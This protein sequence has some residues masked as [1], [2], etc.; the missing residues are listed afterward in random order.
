MNLS[1]VSK[2]LWC[3]H[4]L[5]ILLLTPLLLLPLVFTL[6]EKEGRCLYV[7]IL[8]AVYWC[9]EALPLAVT[10]ML[11]VCLFPTLGILPSKK[12]CPQYFLE[13]NFLFLSGLVMASSIEEWGLHRRIALKVLTIVGVKPA[14]LILGM[15]LT[16][17][18]LSMWLSNT[19]TTAMMLPIATAILESL[20]GD[21]ETLKE[22]CKERQEPDNEVR[23]PVKLH[24]LPS[25]H[26]EKQ[27]LSIEGP[28]VEEQS[29]QRSVEEIRTES[30]YQ[31]KVWKGFLI[32]IPYAASIGGTATLTGTAPNLILIG[33]LKS[34]FPD[35]D[36][37]NFG[38]WFAFAFPL[39]A[40]LPVVG[41]L[42]IAFLHGGL[43]TRLCFTRTDH[44]AAAEARARTM[45]EDDYK[46]LGPIK[47]YPQIT[48][49]LSL[50]AIHVSIN[51]LYFMI[52]ATVGCSYAFMLPVSTPPNSIAFASGHLMVK[53]MVKTGIVMNIL[54]ILCVSLAMNTWGVAMFDL[55]SY[56]EWAHPINKTL[57]DVH[58][59]LNATL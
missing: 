18:F 19:A 23:L 14:W 48:S 39:H 41:W 33:Q 15:M 12:V 36:A 3:V 58:L 50:Q 32:C 20:F 27:M 28:D 56:P 52:P 1:A 49:S 26:T 51:P 47:A 59:A 25:E 5:L 29:D 6:P 8:M 42:W 11:P 40:D 43:N 34:Y 21:L 44:R 38:S 17:S 35:C 57:S 37:I 10:A 7:V 31:M 24:S 45:I 30:A 54:G 22:K 9:T 46:K 2:K 4:K 16:S 55:N 53:D 13:T